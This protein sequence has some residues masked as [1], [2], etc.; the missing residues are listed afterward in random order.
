MTIKE[1]IKSLVLFALLVGTIAFLFSG[2]VLSVTF[3]TQTIEQ[4]VFQY[5]NEERTNRNL[6][7]LGNDTNLVVIAKGWS[8]N[9]TERGVLEHGN[10]NQRLSS[11]NYYGVYKC[12][13]IIEY[14]TNGP[15]VTADPE[16]Y[17]NSNSAIARVLVDGWLNSPPHREIMLT[18]QSG[19]MGVAVS[20]KG[21]GSF[22]GVVDFKFV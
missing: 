11:I 8:D 22:Y 21:L 19:D 18:N 1:T 15:F 10:F 5:V 9:M 2:T 7:L 4:Y 3:K 17:T 20:I 14:Y 16:M 6:P 13:E 12:G